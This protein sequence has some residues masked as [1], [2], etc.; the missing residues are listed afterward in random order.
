[1]IDKMKKLISRLKRDNNKK[2][3]IAMWMIKQYLP[4]LNSIKTALKIAGY[5]GYRI[6]DIS[7]NNQITEEIFRRIKISPFIIADFT[8]GKIE[9]QRGNVFYEAGYARGKGVKVIHTCRNN[10][11]NK[12][13]LSFDTNKF[14]HV[15]WNNLGDD[16]MNNFAKKLAN[17]IKNSIGEGKNAGERSSGISY[18]KKKIQKQITGKVL[19]I[20]EDEKL[21]KVFLIIEDSKGKVGAIEVYKW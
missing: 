20:Q 3:F 13:K 15:T 7:H 19:R 9:G 14:P 12:Q 21:E 2:V 18:S 11:L 17:H 10:M 1:M 6:D 4:L 16:S 8:H 5:E